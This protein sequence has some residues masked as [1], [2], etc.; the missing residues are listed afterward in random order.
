MESSSEAKE[1]AFLRRLKQ[2]HAPEDGAR[3]ERQLGR[4]ERPKRLQMGGDDEEDDAPT[5]VDADTN[6][7]ITSSDYQKLVGEPA[8]GSK[9]AA[10]GADEVHETTATA[11]GEVSQK[12]DAPDAEQ[13]SVAQ[14]GERRRKRV[15]KVV[16]EDDE[17]NVSKDRKGEKGNNEEADSKM[18]SKISNKSSAK[19]T[20]KKIK[21]SF[22]DNS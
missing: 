3:R 13:A 17:D 15:G 22:D 8:S 9:D 1:P 2:Q 12:I 11:T 10:R 20:R 14:V 21:L 6:E 4:P 19:K 7:V 18:P 5:Y 16:G